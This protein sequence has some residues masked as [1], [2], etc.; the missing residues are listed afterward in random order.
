[1]LGKPQ[2]KMLSV[3]LA[4]VGFAHIMALQP[5]RANNDCGLLMPWLLRTWAAATTMEA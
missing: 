5:Y 1:M 3:G 4:L 2:F